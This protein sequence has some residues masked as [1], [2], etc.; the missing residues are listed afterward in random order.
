MKSTTDKLHGSPGRS[1]GA[2]K[3]EAEAEAEEEEEPAPVV[4]VAT[5]LQEGGGSSE[6]A[7]IVDIREILSELTMVPDGTDLNL[8][9]ADEGNFTLDDE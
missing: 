7:D 8:A 2:A 6:P 3:A 1:G 5:L 4:P 9:A